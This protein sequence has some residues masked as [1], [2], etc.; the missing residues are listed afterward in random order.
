VKLS[1]SFA[2]GKVYYDP[3]I[4]LENAS[5]PKKRKQKGEA[6]SES[7]PRIFHHYTR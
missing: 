5:D 4:K 2:D 6:S 1:N 7:N 3:G